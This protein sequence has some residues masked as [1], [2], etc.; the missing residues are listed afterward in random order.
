MN[1]HTYYVLMYSY[2]SEHDQSSHQ[3]LQGRAIT[4]TM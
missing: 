2:T 1:L 3:V 4:Q